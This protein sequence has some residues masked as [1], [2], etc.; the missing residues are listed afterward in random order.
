MEI[1][2][3]MTHTLRLIPILACIVLSGCQGD[4]PTA[5]TPQE[6]SIED[7]EI[8]IAVPTQ[9]IDEIVILVPTPSAT[10]TATKMPPAGWMPTPTRT[11]TQKIPE[12]ESNPTLVY[13]TVFPRVEP[14]ATSH[15]FSRQ[16]LTNLND[17]VVFVSNEMGNL[18]IFGASVG[19]GSELQ[20]TFNSAEDTHPALSPDGRMVAFASDRNGNFDLFLLDVEG[21]TPQQLTYHPADDTQPAWS[22]DGSQIV[23]VSKRD[24]NNELYI[25]DVACVQ[26]ENGCPDELYRMTRSV[27]DDLVPDWSPDGQRIAFMTGRDGNLEI[28]HAKTDGTD[29]VRLTENPGVDGFPTWSPDSTMIAFHS[30]REGNFDIYAKAVD[31]DDEW[32]LTFAEDEDLAPD[33]H[34][35][36]ILYMSSHGSKFNILLIQ[37]PGITPRENRRQVWSTHRA[38]FVG[39]PSWGR[40]GGFDETTNI[41]QA[42]PTPQ[43]TEI[44]TLP[45]KLSIERP[46]FI[47]DFAWHPDGSQI[48]AAGPLALYF[49]DVPSMTL[50]DRVDMDRYMAAYALDFSPDGNQLATGHYDQRIRIWDPLT[51]QILTV[52]EGSVGE[53]DM[54]KYSPDGGT[55]ASVGREGELLLWDLEQGIP[56]ISLFNDQYYQADAVEFSSDGR[57]VAFAVGPH[58]LSI[59]DRQQYRFLEPLRPKDFYSARSIEA[60]AINADGTLIA[61]GADEYHGPD[62]GQ[63]QIWDLLRGETLIELPINNERVVFLQFTRDG[64]QL[65]GMTEDGWI[66]FWDTSN[67]ELLNDTF[68]RGFGSILKV[69]L[70]P[71]ERWLAIATQHKIYFVD[72][73]EF[74]PQEGSSE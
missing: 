29:I 6:P 14:T 63:V 52:L 69:E 46:E 44:N 2:P 50:T 30:E 54:V 26:R 35:D 1:S 12:S 11:P 8:S 73:D 56:Q 4:S 34:G 51:K 41:F 55:I 57:L 13:P 42:R 58:Y 20:L 74:L 23:F 65:I 68:L 5:N 31:G 22:P 37:A 60:V 17:R 45:L 61:A 71:G 64:E 16:S 27:Y 9:T 53:I 59:F 21:G 47:E 24:G 67:W 48:V 49:F 18:E 33:W 39:Y 10:S 19:S 38:T 3:G 15:Y 66:Y 72:T 70:A 40:L 36:H 7:G 28:Y 43:P 32:R 62:P 25:I